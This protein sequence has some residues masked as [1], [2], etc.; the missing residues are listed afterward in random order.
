MIGSGLLRYQKDQEY[1][2]FDCEAS[3]LNLYSALPTQISFLTYTLNNDLES[4]NHYI[5]WSE[6]ELRMSKGASRVTRFDYA[7]YKE[8]AE[9]SKKILEKA[10]DYI[11][12]EKYIISAQNVLGYDSMIL[13]NWR[14]KLGLKPRLDFALGSHNDKIKVLDTLALS[15]AYKLSIKPD[16]SNPIAFLAFQYRMLD[17]V[18]RGLKTSISAMCKEFQIE[19]KEEEMHEALTDCIKNKEIFKQLVWKLEI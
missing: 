13:N 18:Q 10:E 12:S 14:R 11:Y 17:I 6:N 8:R 1:I 16:T 3:S 7:S 15:K 19:F 9:D 2:T 4:H 5:Y